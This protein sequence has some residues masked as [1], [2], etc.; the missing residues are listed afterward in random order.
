VSLVAASP[1]ADH[2]KEAD[3][4]IERFVPGRDRLAARA[5]REHGWCPALQCYDFF[6]RFVKRLIAR[7]DGGGTDTSR[8]YE[9]PELGRRRHI[10]RGLP[11]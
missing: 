1:D 10:R 3:K 8:D 4:L 2:R 9:Y 7:R 5:H 11:Q 6:K